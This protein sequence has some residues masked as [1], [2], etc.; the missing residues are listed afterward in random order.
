MLPFK[1]GGNMPGRNMGERLAI[2]PNRNAHP[3]P[4]RPQR[5]RPLAEHRL[6]RD[7]GRVTSFPATGTYVQDPNDPNGYL[8]DRIGVTWV[9]FDPRTGTGGNATQTIYVGVADLG[10]SIYRSTNGG[11]TWSALPG[12]PTGFMPHHAVLGSN[13]ILYVTYNNKGGP[14]DGEKGD[15]WKIRHRQRRLDPDQPGA[16][17]Q[18][19]RLLRLRRPGR[20]RAGPRH[21]DGLGPQLVVA[22]HDDLAQ[23]ERGRH[24]DPHLGLRR[25]TR[26]ARYRYVQDI[27]AS[28]WLTFGGQPA[29]SR[30]HAQAGLDGRR[31]GDRPVQLEPH[32]VR[33][34]RHHLR[35]RRPARPGIRA[36]RSTSG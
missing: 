12:Q 19:R 27:S 35:L 32:D 6:R 7:L 5:E 13:G 11:A 36:G 33:H 15:V 24:L 22:G 3:L 16:V 1:S 34:R 2:D 29:A 26:T 4:G 30:G 14:Y 31:P 17:D 28:P 20:G 23:H 21:G 18:R 9:V 10:T 25:H 8:S